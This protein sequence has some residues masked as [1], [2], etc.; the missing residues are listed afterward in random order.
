MGG[1]DNAVGTTGF[2]KEFADNRAKG[3]ECTHATDGGAESF[4]EG[5]EGVG[6]GDSCNEGEHC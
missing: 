4:R 3:D 6:Q 1:L 5:G 2:N